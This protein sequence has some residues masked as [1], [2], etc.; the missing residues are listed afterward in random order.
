MVPVNSKRTNGK[1]KNIDHNRQSTRD[2]S[3]SNILGST[4]QMYHRR[5]LPPVPYPADMRP[6]STR[7][8]AWTVISY[9][10]SSSGL[11]EGRRL[12]VVILRWSLRYDV[13]S[14][15]RIFKP[16]VLIFVPKSART[17][18]QRGAPDHTEY[19]VW[20]LDAALA[21]CSTRDPGQGAGAP[22]V[23][24]CTRPRDLHENPAK[25]HF[26]IQRSFRGSMCG[27]PVLVRRSSSRTSS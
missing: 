14:S 24:P 6:T 3:A 15:T 22:R 20:Q 8:R 4:I 27:A 10:C 25:G 12:N 21:A 11:V 16:H 13:T 26:H 18:R 7:A 19:R 5:T 23:R 17:W 9:P 2:G 1:S